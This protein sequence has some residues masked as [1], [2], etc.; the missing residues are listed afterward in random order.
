M[1]KSSPGDSPIHGGCF[2]PSLWSKGY[3]NHLV[4]EQ[5]N[6]PIAN[7]YKYIITNPLVKTKKK[8]A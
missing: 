7:Y 5:I 1:C 8:E 4:A 2:K 3:G 6:F